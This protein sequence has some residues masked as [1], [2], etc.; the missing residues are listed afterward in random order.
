MPS[1]DKEDLDEEIPFFAS[2]EQ[3]G[4]VLPEFEDDQFEEI[5]DFFIDKLNMINPKGGIQ[6]VQE[7]ILEN[8]KEE[9]LKRL[10]CDKLCSR[11]CD[12]DASK[13]LRSKVR[14]KLS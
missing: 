14:P 11:N 5:K 8:F 10:K 2:T 7:F 6:G 9:D 4:D 1:P 13:F 12:N 3:P